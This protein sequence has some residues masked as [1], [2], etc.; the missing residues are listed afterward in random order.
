[1]EKLNLIM[2]LMRVLRTYSKRWEQ[3][4][5][6]VFG[7]WRIAPQISEEVRKNER[8]VINDKNVPRETHSSHKDLGENSAE[9]KKQRPSASFRE[10]S[11]KIL[12]KSATP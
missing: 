9:R 7:T 5:W 8:V 11:S 12:E 10:I 6:S 1:M 4:S 3:K 2:I